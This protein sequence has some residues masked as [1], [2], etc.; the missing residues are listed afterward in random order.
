MERTRIIIIIIIVIKVERMHGHIITSQ[1]LKTKNRPIKT[2]IVSHIPLDTIREIKGSH[3][4]GGSQKTLQPK[5]RTKHYNLH[6]L[7]YTN[8]VLT[9]QFYLSNVVPIQCTINAWNC[10]RNE[11]ITN[12]SQIQVES[13]FGI[14]EATLVH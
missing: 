14:N 6:M 12:I 8:F 4:N 9:K 2:I 1:R 5:N 7:S 11:S 13:I 10:H 3:R